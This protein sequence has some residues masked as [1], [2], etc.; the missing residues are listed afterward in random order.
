M[1]R[2]PEF[3]LRTS[4]DQRRFLPESEG[5]LP[6]S[7]SSWWMGPAAARLPD[8]DIHVLYLDILQGGSEDWSPAAVAHIRSFDLSRWHLTLTHALINLV[9]DPRLMSRVVECRPGDL[10]I[11]DV[12]GA[13]PL[14]RALREGLRPLAQFM[15]D[16]GAPYDAYTLLYAAQRGIARNCLD[17]LHPLALTAKT[18]EYGWTPLHVARLFGRYREGDV[19]AHARRDWAE[20]VTMDG[21]DATDIC[22]LTLN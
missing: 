1:P 22:A 9:L 17:L 19:I 16:A 15:I 10:P 5:G 12:R 18:D 3:V 7:P 8:V 21:F 11:R 6:A 14:E 13:R 4:R 2:P 20:A